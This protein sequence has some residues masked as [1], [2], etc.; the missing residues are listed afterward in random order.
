MWLHSEVVVE[1]PTYEFGVTKF[2]LLWAPWGIPL[3]SCSYLP[4]APEPLRK[5]L[6]LS[7]PQCPDLSNE[8]Y[9]SQ[10]LLFFECQKAFVHYKKSYRR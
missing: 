1:F 4:L 3:G 5:S 8:D 10:T 7:D 2:N 9:G 6:N